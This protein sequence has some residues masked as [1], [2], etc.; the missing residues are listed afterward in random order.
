M[1]VLI[2]NFNDLGELQLLDHWQLPSPPSGDS[3]G[4]VIG[5]PSAIESLSGI[6]TLLN[7]F[8]DWARTQSSDD[9]YGDD[10]AIYEKNSQIIASA[11]AALGVRLTAQGH[12]L[13]T[14]VHALSKHKSGDEWK[15]D[16]LG[17]HFPVVHGAD[18]HRPVCF[19]GIQTESPTT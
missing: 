7:S 12:T 11:K 18:L 6:Y 2:S 14:D 3:T 4:G 15:P 17:V 10:R 13:C 1:Y 5:P 16:G 19:F 9:E 8:V